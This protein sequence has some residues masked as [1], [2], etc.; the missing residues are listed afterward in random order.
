MIKCPILIGISLKSSISPPQ[1][2]YNFYNQVLSSKR[3]IYSCPD[4]E[5][6][7]DE[8]FYIFENNWIK[9]T[10]KIPL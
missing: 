2:A 10:L 1:A 5:S 8:S 6:G 4:N 9:E 3:E 7:I